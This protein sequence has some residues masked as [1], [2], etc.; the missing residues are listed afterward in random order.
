M[1]ILGT[2]TSNTQTA[3]VTLVIGRVI[4]SF[5]NGALGTIINRI[6]A[7]WFLYKELALA[8]SISVVCGRLGSA[9]S[10]AVTGYLVEVV[11]MQSCLWIGMGFMVIT[12][13]SCIALAYINELGDDIINTAPLHMDRKEIWSFVKSLDGMYWC[14]VVMVFISY[15]TVS[16]F[17]INGP[18]FAAV[19]TVSRT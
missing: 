5:G 4:S 3:F 12:T 1:F 9:L 15:G 17:T 2:Y 8:F 14:F 7:S 11:G 18:N 19:R 10:F 13:A 16:T 6:K